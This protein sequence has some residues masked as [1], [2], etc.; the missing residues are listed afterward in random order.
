[1]AKK[2]GARKCDQ[3]IIVS[4]APSVNKTPIGSSV[5]PIPYP[6]SEEFIISEVVS[7]N[8]NFNSKKVF[9]K[10]SHSKQVTGDEAG[11]LGGIK[12]GTVSEKSEP[13][14]WS[15]SV[16]ANK[17]NVV[18]KDDLHFMQG[19]NTIGRLTTKD[20][21][22]GVSVDDN[23]QIEGDT[24]PPDLDIPF[25]DAS[26][27]GGDKM[28]LGLASSTNPIAS[29][30]S[31]VLGALTGS[32][33]LL[34]T[35]Q[36]KYETEEL[37]LWGK[38]PLCLKRTYISREKFS[39]MF[40]NHWRYGYEQE[41]KKIEENTYSLYLNDGRRF[42]FKKDNDKFIDLGDLGVEIEQLSDSYF[43]IH[44]FDGKIL[45]FIDEKLI[46]VEGANNNFVSLVYDLDNRIEKIINSEGSWFNFFYNDKNLVNK[47]VDNT[48]R[49]WLFAYDFLNNLIKTQNPKKIRTS[50]EYIPYKE[51]DES[52]SFLLTKVINH[53][54]ISELEVSYTKDAKVSSYK[55]GEETFTYTYTTNT[56]ITKQSDS[57]DVVHYGLD[58]NGQ[59]KAIT[60]NDGST[61]K[62][63]YDK[64]TRIATFI[65]QGGNKTFKHFDN[66]NRVIKEIDQE[67]KE[68]IFKYEGKNPYPISIIEDKKEI[69]YTY[70]KNANLL[71]ENDN[72]IVQKFE[73]D[74]KGNTT[75][76]IDAKGNE[77][78]IEYDKNSRPIKY[79]D[80]L[81]E[82]TQVN[83]DL[84]NRIETII[85]AN[86]NVSVNY[87][88]ELDNIIKTQQKEHIIS[89]EYDEL[90][91][92]V[93]VIDPVNN[94]TKFEYDKY[95]RII[96]Q[97]KPNE[98]EKSFIYNKDNTL[99]TLIREDKTQIDY[100]YNKAKRLVQIKSEDENFEYDYDSLGNIISANSKDSY[101]EYIYDSNANIIN[102]IQN[103]IE[104]DKT[105]DINSNKMISLIMFNKSFSYQRDDKDNISSI[106]TAYDT[107]ELEY[108][109]NQILT[110]RKY[111]NSL[112][113]EITYDKNYNQIQ[114]KTANENIN[115]EYN[116][117]GQILK[118]NDNEYTYD[119]LN[120]LVKTNNQ[121][122][123]YDKVGNNISNNS[124][125]E[126]QTN[127]L[128]KDD[129][130]SYT[131]D[132]RGNLKEK[133]NQITKEKIQYRF[134]SLNQLV[135]VKRYS[136][137][138]KLIDELE[139]T[140]DALNRRI[141]K[142]HNNEIFHYLYDGLNIVAIL[143]EK[144][145]LLATILHDENIDKP[146]SI[147]TYDTSHYC[148]EK[149]QAMTLD[150]QYEINKKYTKT[151]YYHRDHQGS[152]IALT[153][154][155]GKVIES[156]IY[157][158]SYGKILQ[159][160]KL[161]ETYNPYCYTGREFDSHDLYYYRA[162]YYDPTSQRF[163][164]PDPIEFLS[165]DYNFYRYVGND[166]VNFTDPSGLSG[167]RGFGS[168]TLFD[169][170]FGGGLGGGGR[171][172]GASSVRQIKKTVPAAKTAT[173]KE[174]GVKV[175]GKEEKKTSRKK[176]KNREPQTYEKRV[177]NEDGTT[178]YTL[179]DK[180]TGELHQVTYDK[181]GYPN[182]SEHKYTGN[183]GKSEVQIDMKGN[184]STDF[185]AANEK[186]GFV[187]SKGNI[188]Q[189]SHPEG[190]TWH[191]H[192][193]GKTMQLVK[194]GPHN[195]TPHTGG[196]S[197]RK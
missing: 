174:T 194:Q 117:I 184:H 156:I 94:K 135:N 113:E 79:I 77:T 64:T 108:D 176:N 181:D 82:T 20:K 75:K 7:P 172:G 114:I 55:Q 154:Q 62:Q 99:K 39:G 17:Y 128:L 90:N 143:D 12:S 14:E 150:E 51:E 60:H 96:K 30:A 188:T 87:Y 185:K 58:E 28:A 148:C 81:N 59:I 26:I 144:K 132:L 32:P 27:G 110:K 57:G 105:Y 74:K 85:D 49:V 19:K 72:G 169:A 149:Y 138:G 141:K 70:D 54:N 140:Y 86:E 84:K 165:G 21:G 126:E 179:K 134:N 178:T 118:R 111:P 192:Q 48:N 162:R 158:E 1:M 38:L 160:K 131:Y 171:L 137:N 175:K 170:G 71:E 5:V 180:K 18:R 25:I 177:K 44:F 40:G 52:K 22:S 67:D 46:H 23:G 147:T 112:E 196:V 93:S 124:F 189:N 66:R 76:I 136:L 97:I 182:F 121:E 37:M 34:K 89:F 186:A 61:S 123:E 35:A 157:D 142:R 183:A 101:L 161:V 83:Y 47:V 65:D 122:F 41:F 153:N 187:N 31:G 106:K 6:V 109:E 173:K 2:F 16:R 127:Q 15:P 63:S 42:D 115:Y 92:L 33:V 88:D 68:T 195:N 146:L 163:L 129:N 152:I 151:Y 91:R 116:K 133:I 3:Y 107:I 95:N 73:Y 168:K 98:K 130:Y 24:L 120:R 9:V 104:L 78:K 125:Y 193:D 159:H 53:K 197:K 56:M 166:P 29:A 80:P 10:K 45:T 164:S 36:L 100:N 8:V 69:K 145:K 139:F 43:R 50:Y 103:D 119:E 4:V 167:L 155:E 190:Y 102:Q 11:T 191:H 13:L